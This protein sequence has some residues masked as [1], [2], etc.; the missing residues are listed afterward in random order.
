M[1]ISV[2]LVSSG[3]TWSWRLQFLLNAQT[4]HCWTRHNHTDAGTPRYGWTLSLI[5]QMSSQYKR[6]EKENKGQN[7]ITLHY[8][9]SPCFLPE[10]LSYYKQS[11]SNEKFLARAC[12]QDILYIIHWHH[13]SW[14][15]ATRFK[16]YLFNFCLLQINVNRGSLHG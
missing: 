8:G 7:L 6:R 4:D 11:W 13:Q 16:S 3:W 2:R 15:F 10:E 5:G 1:H 9:L 14:K 12:F